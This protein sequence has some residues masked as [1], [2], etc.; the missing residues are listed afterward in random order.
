MRPLN[1]T[2]ILLLL[3]SVL[4]SAC[5]PPASSGLQETGTITVGYIPTLGFSPF[6]VALEKGYFEEQGLEVEL[7]SFRSGATMIAP[8]TT[9]QLD[10][11]A[12]E[13]GTAFFNAIS[14][15]LDM[16][17]VAALA[18]QPPGYGAVPLVVRKDLFDL[19]EVSGPGDL[20]GRKVSLNV[21]RG[22]A[23]YLLA[24]ALGKADLTVDDVEIV[25]LPFPDMPAALENEAVEAAILPHPLAA[26]AIGGG[27]AAALIE[28]DQIVDNPQNGVLYFGQRMLD[29][30]NREAGVRFLMAYLKAARDLQGDGWREE[31]NATILNQ[32]T[33]VPIAAIQGGVAYFHDPNGEIHQASTERIQAYLVGRGYT[34]YSEPFP[35]SELLDLTYLEEAL[36]RLGNYE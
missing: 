6:Y 17:A 2:L 20:E 12:G 28:G 3:M 18:S 21:E 19:G 27:Y 22:M 15:E 35:L 25:T 13:T 5:A 26:K 11:G 1:R 10:V 32:Y 8:L 24:E 30:G 36:E 9:G 31:T 4:V 23:E 16:R 34:E 14:Q 33:N 7:Q 29:P